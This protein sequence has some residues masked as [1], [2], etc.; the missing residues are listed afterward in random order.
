MRTDGTIARERFE[1]PRGLGFDRHSHD[2]H[3]QLAWASSGVLLI[4]AD[5]HRW[6]LP[7]TLAVWIPAGLAHA[8]RAL[9]TT[10]LE[11]IYFDAETSR[12]SWPRPTLIA[13]TPLAR[14]LIA[15]LGTDL[16]VDARAR[17]EAVLIDVLAPAPPTGSDLPL[18]RDPRA[19]SI[20]DLLLDHPGDPRTLDQFAAAQGASTR[21]LLRAF[22]SDTGMSFTQ[23][24][25]HVRLQAAVIHLADGATVTETAELV[26]YSTASA[27]VAAFRRGMGVTPATYLA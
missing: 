6:V 17:A 22:T 25:T 4:E 7:P 11:G 20:A 12:V 8:T 19:R 2:R 3:H 10:T 1:L 18:P 16:D 27:F 15:H 9:R 24:R 14:H 26:G 21:T 13:V 5:E 23:W